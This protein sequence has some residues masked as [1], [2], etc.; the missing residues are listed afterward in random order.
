VGVDLLNDKGAELDLAELEDLTV[1]D[2][3][4]SDAFDGG[5]KPAIFCECCCTS[6]SC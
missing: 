1:E 4:S 2:L 6:C 5:D 3:L